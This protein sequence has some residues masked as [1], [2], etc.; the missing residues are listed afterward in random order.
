MDSATPAPESYKD[1]FWRAEYLH[2]VTEDDLKDLKAEDFD[3]LFNGSND[4][5]TILGKA[6][7]LSYLF[8][9]SND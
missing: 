5:N 3:L 9:L 7:P 1:M 8:V 4:L 6:V 2:T